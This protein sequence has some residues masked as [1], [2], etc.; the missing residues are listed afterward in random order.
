MIPGLDQW[1]KDLAFLQLPLQG[2]DATFP[3]SAVV[4]KSRDDDVIMYLKDFPGRVGQSEKDVK[5]KSISSK[6]FYDNFILRVM[7]AAVILYQSC[8]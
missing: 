4:S 8:V 1:V 5:T 2:N 6:S 7:M 3:L